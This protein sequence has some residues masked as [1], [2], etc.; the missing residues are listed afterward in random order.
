VIVAL[1]AVELLKNSVRSPCAIRDHGIAAVELF[2][3]LVVRGWGFVSS[4]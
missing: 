4:H 2:K 3:K 1:A